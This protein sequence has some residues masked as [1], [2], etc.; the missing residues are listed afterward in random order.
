MLKHGDLLSGSDESHSVE[1][2]LYEVWK[3]NKW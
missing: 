2:G 3:E 1:D